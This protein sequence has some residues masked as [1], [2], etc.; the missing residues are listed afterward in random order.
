MSRQH[1]RRP[2][3][4]VQGKQEIRNPFGVSSIQ[5]ARRLVSEKNP[6]AA[7]ERTCQSHALLLPTGEC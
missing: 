4:G 6:G 3:F 1:K 7:R 5:V 2:L